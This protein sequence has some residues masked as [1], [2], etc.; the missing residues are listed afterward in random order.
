MLEHAELLEK[1]DTQVF[2]IQ[3]DVDA[4]IKK[5]LDKLGTV[6]EYDLPVVAEVTPPNAFAL[7]DAIQAG[8]RKRA[9]ILYRQLIE[10]GASAEEVHGTLAWSARGVVLASNTKS[11]DEAGMKPYPYDKARAVARK[12]RPGEAVAQSSELVRLYHDA[13]MGLGSLEDLI[14]IYLLRKS[15]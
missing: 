7:V 12:L 9:W 1:S 3:P 2:V 14:E 4:L 8:D 5:K 13:R 10:S 15:S 6:E 11:A